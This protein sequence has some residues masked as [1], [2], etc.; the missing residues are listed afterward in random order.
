[1]STGRV[2]RYISRSRSVEAAGVCPDTRTFL[3]GGFQHKKDIRNISVEL[4]NSLT[5]LR[6][7]F[8][9]F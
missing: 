6:H 4:I 8:R 9:V 7:L 2:A 3:I 5:P 1:M